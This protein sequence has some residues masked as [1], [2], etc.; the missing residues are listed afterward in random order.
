[1]RAEDV[2][3]LLRTRPFN[4]FR[5]YLSDG[6]QHEVRHPD[7]AIV[8]S[9]TVFIGIPGPAGPDGPVQRVVH[10]SLLHITRAEI[11]DEA[12]ASQS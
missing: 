9:S 1:M 11:I 3:E 8:T 5:L 10:C 2:I 12:H 7:L 6:S 4:P